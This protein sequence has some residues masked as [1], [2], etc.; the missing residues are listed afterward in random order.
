MLRARTEIGK[1]EESLK[2][3]SEDS[4][5]SW[6]FKL[7]ILVVESITGL[8]GKIDVRLFPE[9]FGILRMIVNE[10]GEAGH[11]VVVPLKRELEPLAEWLE[12]DVICGRNGVGEALRRKPDAA[13]IIAPEKGRELELITKKFR[14]K[15]IFVLGAEER[16]IRVSADKW[17]TYIAL[18]GKVP[19][20]RT[21]RRP[22]SVQGKILVKP[23]D[24][25]G[26]DGIGFLP[27]NSKTKRMIFQEFCK[28]EHASCCLLIGNTGGTVLSVNKQ[29]IAFRGERFEY[30]GGEVPLNHELARECAEVALTAAETLNLRGY[31]GVDLV[32][33]EAPYFI[34]LNP[35]LTTSFIALSRVIKANFGK[36]LVSTLV[37][38]AFPPRPKLK[39][40]SILRILRFKQEVMIDSGKLRELRGVPEVVAPPLI[41]KSYM[42]ESPSILVSSSGSSIEE[43]KRKLFGAVE[44]TLDLLGVD[45][46]AVSWS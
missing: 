43:A 16:A 42:G 11:D 33:G 39:G 32:V 20:P 21:W 7:R 34:E 24:G 35:R 28:G 8:D 17:R 15:G 37:E 14:K 2:V 13:L 5:N 44:E 23:I 18:K 1:W 36:L 22:P 6:R 46:N 27:T 19:Q 12:A 10:F 45:D 25:V 30:L 26:C 9:G 3:V 40:H 4:R 41:S 31:C 38:G 29:E